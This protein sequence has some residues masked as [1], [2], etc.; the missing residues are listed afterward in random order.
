MLPRRV[1]NGFLPQHLAVAQDAAG[2]AQRRA[3][4][5]AEQQLRRRWRVAQLGMR[6]PEIVAALGDVVGELVAEREAEPARRAVGADQIDA[7][8]LR[9]L[10]AVE[11]EARQRRA[12]APGA[13]SRL[14]SPL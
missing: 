11:R 6:E 7:R 1:R 9:L 8:E 10:A 2:A 13:T 3:R 4:Q 12:A 5:F 14:P